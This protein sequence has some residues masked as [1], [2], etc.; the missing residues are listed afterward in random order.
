AYH[1]PIY[2]DVDGGG[3]KAN[4]DTLGWP[5][6]GKLNVAEA[7]ALLAAFERSQKAP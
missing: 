5:I 4:G 2:V 7:Q 3:F 1:N 6:L